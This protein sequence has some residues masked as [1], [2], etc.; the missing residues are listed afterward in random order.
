[1]QL[2]TKKKVKTAEEFAF[3]INKKVRFYR[4]N[5]HILF[6]NDIIIHRVATLP[7]KPGI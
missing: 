3:C 2:K 4:Q 5:L 7:G 6:N 1:M